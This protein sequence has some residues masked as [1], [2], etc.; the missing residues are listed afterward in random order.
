MAP[1]VRDDLPHAVRTVE[2]EWI[3]LSDGTRLAARLWLPE[4]AG[5]VPAILEYLP[6]RLS[7]GRWMYIDKS[8]LPNGTNLGVWL[9][10]TAL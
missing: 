10:I 4:G 9:D 1:R 2:T 5:R 3:E 7:D 8:Q 6:Y